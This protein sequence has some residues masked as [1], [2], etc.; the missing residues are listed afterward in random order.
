M[1][2]LAIADG[3]KQSRLPFFKF[4]S[5]SACRVGG[6]NPFVNEICNY[7]SLCLCDNGNFKAPLSTPRAMTEIQVQLYEMLQV[8]FPSSF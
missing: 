3:S 8:L 1:A 4:F 5:D 7:V 2:T 6:K